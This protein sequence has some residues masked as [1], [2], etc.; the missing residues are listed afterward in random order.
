MVLR[1]IALLIGLTCAAAWLGSCCCC[2]SSSRFRAP[3]GQSSGF[4]TSTSTTSQT[5]KTESTPAK[6]K[7]DSKDH[8]AKPDDS[9]DHSAGQVVYERDGNIYRLDL[10]S[11]DEKEVTTAGV[12]GEKS[13]TRYGC[14]T[15]IDENTVAFLEWTQGPDGG[16]KDRKIQFGPFD[17]EGDTLTESKKPTGLGYCPKLEKLYYLEQTGTGDEPGSDWGADLK[18]YEFP[19][20]GD[21]KATELSSWYGDVGLGHARIRV[22]PDGKLASVPRFPTDVS[23]FYGMY[24]LMDG[25]SVDAL[26]ERYLGQAFVTSIDLTMAEAYA[27]IMV[28]D[29]SIDLAPGLYNLNLVSHENEL[30]AGLNNLYGL[31]VS[32]S[33][34]IAIVC[35]DSGNLSSIDL[36]S[37]EETPLG[38][39]SD[40]DVWPK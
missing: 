8:S 28:L 37:G 26:P 17:S 39:G 20:S 18:L 2:G 19:V 6:N 22:S 7:T 4:T 10:A 12:A 5:T 40:P 30:I 33:L 38:A 24:H 23:D 1:R 35:D 15:F 27:T 25:S 13:G 16:V 31:S 29:N 32:E 11:G 9:S 3:F 34:G 14:P 21:P 36:D